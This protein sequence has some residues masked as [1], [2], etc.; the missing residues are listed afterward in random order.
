MIFCAFYLQFY[1]GDR[2]SLKMEVW[3]TV[4]VLRLGSHYVDF[5]A[6]VF[7]LAQQPSHLTGLLYLRENLDKRTLYLFSKITATGQLHS[8]MRFPTQENTLQFAMRWWSINK[9]WHPSV[10]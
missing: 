1:V 3:S 4:L 9:Y 8:A 6:A 10:S 2:V 7:A 5:P